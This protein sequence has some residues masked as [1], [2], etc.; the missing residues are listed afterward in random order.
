MPKLFTTEYYELGDDFIHF[1]GHRHR[2]H[3]KNWSTTDAIVP[4]REWCYDFAAGR[5]QWFSLST[6]DFQ[7]QADAFAFLMRWRGT[8]VQDR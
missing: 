7:L 4:V 6:I 2:V 8:E 5:Y 1:K 3:I